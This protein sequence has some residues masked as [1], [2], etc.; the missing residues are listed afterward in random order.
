MQRSSNAISRMMTRR[1]VPSRVVRAVLLSDTSPPLYYLLLYGWT[2]VFGTSDVALRLFSTTWSLA[3]LPLL[4]DVA[5]RIG[6]R[7]SV[8]PACILFAL[9]PLAVYYSTEG[10]M[11]SLLWFC[12]LAPLGLTRLTS[13]GEHRTVPSLDCDIRSWVSDPL[14]LSLP[15][16]RYG[17]FSPHRAWKAFAKTLGDL[18]SSF[19]RCDSSLVCQFAGQPW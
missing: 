5:R 15:L 10:R 8:L 3:C 1:R 11:Y 12:V 6:G 4:V 9:S 17:S 16:D 7:D 13:T 2:L 19:G 14:L 18:H